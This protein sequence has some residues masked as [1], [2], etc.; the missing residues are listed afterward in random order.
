VEACR[1]RP[2]EDTVP[3]PRSGH[4]P[5]ASSDALA[6]AIDVGGTT[7]AAGLVDAQGRLLRRGVRPTPVAD[8]GG[9]AT[10]T[11]ALLDL[12][13]ELIAT[14]PD[15]REIVGVGLACAGPLDAVAGTVSPVNIPAWRAEPLVDDVGDHLGLVGMVDLVND[16]IA[17]TV[18][19]HG[20]GAAKGADNVLGV[21]VSTGVGGGL[22]LDGDARLGPS[23]NAGHVGHTVVEIDG[24]PCPCGGRGCVE[25][26]ASATAMVRDAL[27]RGW[28]PG[29]G[30]AGDVADGRALATAA[31]AGDP[32]ALAAVD[33]GSRALA[34]GIVSAAAL[35]D[36]DLV[37]VGGGFAA[38]GEVLFAPLQRHVDAL[39][40]LSFLERLRIVPAALGPD[41]GLVG[42]GLIAHRRWPAP[43]RSTS[44]A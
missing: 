17:M 5:P 8:A 30:S 16:A 38:A 7:L 18:G 31:A 32:V 2:D 11:G 43:S 33:R 36:L 21:V 12:L 6:L 39:R 14:A 40:G 4:P 41:A 29:A 20:C 44:S 15:S 26:R 28:M 35:V 13:D 9:A 3:D 23:G 22:I 24:E 19:E 25:T 1:I 34:A 37:V 27:R 42:A 10:V